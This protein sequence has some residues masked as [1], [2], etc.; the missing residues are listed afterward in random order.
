LF[1]IKRDGLQTRFFR[2]KV[3]REKWL[4]FSAAQNRV[5][6]RNR[7]GR[8]TD[9]RSYYVRQLRDLKLSIDVARLT[10]KQL[11]DYAELCGW[12][13]ARAH[14]RSGQSGEIAGYLGVSMKCDRAIADFAV[15]YASQVNDDFAT[16]WHLLADQA[17]ADS[18]ATQA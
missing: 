2:C 5:R 9:D 7:R 11:L 14:A 6:L 13:L 8:G 10:R 3:N 12:A 15:Q 16:C 18:T 1:D 4:G 17:N